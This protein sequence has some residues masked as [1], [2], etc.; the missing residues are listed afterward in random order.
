MTRSNLLLLCAALCL[1][2]TSLRAASIEEQRAAFRTVHPQVE[3]GNWQAATDRFDV[4][5]TYILW[6]DL[7]ATYLRTRVGLDDEAIDAFL[8]R[9]GT[10]KPA[11]QLRYRHALSLARR[12][13]HA[14]FLQIYETYYRELGEPTLDCS[15]AIAQL[16]LGRSDEAL[17]LARK[18]WLIGRSQADQCDPLFARLKE[19]GFLG[20]DLHVERYRLAVTGRQFRLARYLARSADEETLAE[21]NR[22]LA[23]DE[24]AERFL[25]RADIGRDDPVYHQQLAHA[26]KRRGFSEPV[27]ASR[28][29]QRLAQDMAFATELSDDVTRHAALWAARLNVPEASGLL[30]ALSE[31]AATTE[32]QRWRLRTALRDGDW[33]RVLDVI[34]ELPADESEREQWRYWQAIALKQ[35]GRETDAILSLTALARERSYYGFLAAD[36]L[37]VDYVL[38]A[39]TTDADDAVL[40]DLATKPD[41]IRARELFMVGLDG[42]ARSEWDAAVSRLPI[43]QTLQAAV[44][45]QRWNWHSRAIASAAKAGRYDDLEL[46]YPLPHR[47]AFATSAIAAGIPESW[48]YGI[49]RSE[50]LFMRDVRSGAGA[51]GLMQLMPATGRQTARE[52]KTPYR[53]R[54]TL[55]D[56]V[57]NIQL[58]T[59]YLANMFDRFDSHPALATAAYNAGPARVTRWLPGPQP[60]D[61]RVWIETIPFNE[62]R[63]YVRRVLSSDVIFDWRLTGTANR[64][65]AR[66]PVIPPSEPTRTAQR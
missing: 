47:E 20:A 52:L 12:G 58:G 41:L 43:E 50:S 7:E 14:D 6:P 2:G 36:E 64:L 46:R 30:N 22:W 13:E 57:A 49:A 15:A 39:Q 34:D 63:R 37:G 3:L 29:W 44:L 33:Q 59:R 31:V 23:A 4:L 8:D 18:L 60:L 24:S 17:Q 51:I 1:S 54:D 62:T 35:S 21:A 16:E 28:H 19:T 45:A 53:G 27:N 25:L 10:L 32:V 55:I 56:P 48:A 38:E 9:H 66:L 40:A 65:S 61:A 11:R 5:S 26:A 42:Q